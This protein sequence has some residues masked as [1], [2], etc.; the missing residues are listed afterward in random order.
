MSLSWFHVLATRKKKKETYCTEWEL[1]SVLG[2]AFLPCIA[3]QISH[4][5]LVAPATSPCSR[6]SDGYCHV[7]CDQS[8]KTMELSQLLLLV[9]S[10][11]SPT[12]RTFLCLAPVEHVLLPS[13]C[14]GVILLSYRMV[15]FE[16]FVSASSPWIFQCD[17]IF[18]VEN[19]PSIACFLIFPP[20]LPPDPCLQVSS[21][22]LCYYIISQNL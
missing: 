4:R 20:L 11:Y 7:C 5:F 22:Y 17:F 16:W 13:C 10:E 3:V 9:S 8:Y 19:V 14:L 21:F 18:K 15:F 2:I 6:R 1:L 12:Q